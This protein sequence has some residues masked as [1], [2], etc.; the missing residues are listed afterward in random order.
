[1]SLREGSCPRETSRRAT[2]YTSQSPLS[3]RDKARH[4]HRKRACLWRARQTPHRLRTRKRTRTSHSHTHTTTQPHH[5][6]HTPTSPP[7]PPPLPTSHLPPPTNTHHTTPH[8][9]HQ[10]VL[11][12]RLEVSQPRVDMMNVDRDMEET[13]TAARHAE[14]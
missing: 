5:N 13:A 10:V 4:M 1:M 2:Q 3:Q 12:T 8:H 6:P 14:A 11:P 7:L 9:H